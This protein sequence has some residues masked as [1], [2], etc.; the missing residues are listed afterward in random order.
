MSSYVRCSPA[1]A[2]RTRRS[3]AWRR[4]EI[5]HFGDVGRMVADPLE[6]LGDEQQVRGL[7]DVVRVLHHEGE[8][9]R[10]MLN[11]RNRRPP[12]RARHPRA[13]R[14]RARRR[15]RARREPSRWRCAPSREAATAA[16]SCVFKLRHPLGDV[17]RIIADPLDHA[18]DLERGDDV[19][20]VVGHRRAKAMSWTPA[21]RS[22]SPARRAS[23]RARRRLRALVALTSAASP[24]D[25]MFGETAHLAIR[26]RSRSSPRRTP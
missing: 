6:I 26:P 20:Q 7:A 5:D 25:R 13:L 1:S 4:G 3:T 19:A 14:H 16:R 18:G 11:R 17:L 8:Q 23:C 24:R 22:R 10:K 2:G 15:R 9:V 21:A 12:R